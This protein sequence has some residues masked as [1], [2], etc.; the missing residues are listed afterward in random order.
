[1]N[2]EAINIKE[3]QSERSVDDYSKETQNF[4]EKV[5]RE[6]LLEQDIKT[7]PLSQSEQLSRLRQAWNAEGSPF[8]GQDFD[9]SVIKFN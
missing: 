5:N 4:I 6:Q 3:L 7:L 8:K 9:P 2:E 1:M